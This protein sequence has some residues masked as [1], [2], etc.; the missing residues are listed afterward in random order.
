MSSPRQVGFLENHFEQ[1]LLELAIAQDVLTDAADFVKTQAPV[2]PG[3]G[4]N[5]ATDDP[6]VIL[7]FGQF[8]ARLHAAEGLLARAARLASANGSPVPAAATDVPIA[9]RA[10]LPSPTNASL[11]NAPSRSFSHAARP[12]ATASPSAPTA[13]VTPSAPTAPSAA[14][15]IALIEARA[16]ASDLVAEIA[17]Q[18]VAWG[19]PQRAGQQR[20]DASGQLGHHTA[21]H[22]NY[23]HAGNYYLKGVVPPTPEPRP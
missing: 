9:A 11:S 6:H 3:V 15:L 14:V 18:L 23:H 1:A 21:N 5:H 20:R 10:G 19:G 12:A 7:R 2:P 4:I 16:F 8:R 17:S 22:W 13:A